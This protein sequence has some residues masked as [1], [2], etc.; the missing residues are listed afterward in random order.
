MSQF[1]DKSFEGRF[2]LPGDRHRSYGRVVFD[3]QEGVRL[4]L[5]DTNL[6]RWKDAEGP[7]APPYAEVLHGETLGGTPV[8][9]LDLY[10]THWSVQGFGPSAG[11]VVDGFGGQLL[12]GVHVHRADEVVALT[13]GCS[14]HGLEEFLTGGA[15]DAGVLSPST[16]PHA[17]A[18]VLV[19]PLQR[20]EL[21]LSAHRRWSLSRGTETKEISVS[22]HWEF[23]PALS[24]P[25]IE[26][27]YLGPLMDLVHFAT[28][29]ESYLIGLTAHMAAD[30]SD[31]VEVL[32]RAHPRP[33]RDREVYALA[34]NLAEQDA[35]DQII[36]RWYD[37]RRKIGPVWGVFFAA[38]DRS[39]S[40]LEDRLLG[41]LAFAEGYHR[42]LH[43]SPPLT[44]KQQ[45]DATRAIRE[46]LTDKKVR[47]IY[48]AALAHANS[49]T[50]RERLEFLVLRALEVLGDWWY[51]DH[52][53]LASRLIHTRNW[54]VHWGGRGRHVVDD[55]EGMV[56]LLRGLTLVLY[57]NLLLDLGLSQKDA[58]G[59]VGSGW[60][61]EGAPDDV[62]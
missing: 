10:I 4:H 52:E 36:A 49:Q 7:G 60:R 5:V 6:T 9:V 51:V 61:L 17:P 37:L 33:Q 16:D 55:T 44:R 39:E 26:R 2:W 12:R 13:A 43:D 20:A 40:L 34:L 59:V 14:L 11:D 23:D 27:E 8:T 58:A 56:Q 28:R 15:V 53:V 47:R 46:A 22:A 30:H 3:H 50:Q 42:T 45:K 54:L 57:V 31:S 19:I 21:R 32:Q 62:Y 24:L 1:D 35:P 41:L 48:R 38:I 29:R 25:E 18:D